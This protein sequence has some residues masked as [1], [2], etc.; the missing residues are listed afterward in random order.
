MEAQNFLRSLT[1]SLVQN[2]AA[3]E[4]SEKH[5]ELGTLLSLKVDPTDMG[6]I[7]GRGGKTIDAIRTVMRVFGSKSGARVNI[8]IIEDKPIE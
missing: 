7:I 5:D 1:E 4:I 6:A 8:R 2:T 3:I